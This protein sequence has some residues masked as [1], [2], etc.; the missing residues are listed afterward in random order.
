MR[1]KTLA[2]I[3]RNTHYIHFDHKN[4]LKDE[5]LKDF[6]YQLKES[7]EKFDIWISN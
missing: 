3:D 1:P 4:Q 2:R 5:F 7:N 6:D